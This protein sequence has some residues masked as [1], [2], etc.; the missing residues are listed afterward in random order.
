M[1]G[2]D[3]PSRGL[4]TTAK[5]LA[6]N[7]SR[8][9]FKPAGDDCTFFQKIALRR[10]YLEKAETRVEL[11]G[12]TLSLGDDYIP[13]SR[14]ANISAALVF[15][16]SG[17][18]V[19]LKNIDAYKGIDAKGKIAIVFSPPGRI[20]A[21]SNARR[22]HRQAWRRLYDRQRVCAETRRQWAGGH[23]DFHIWQTGI[24]IEVD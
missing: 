4:D 24:A 8:W 20:A 3:T 14:L 19:K 10:D 22:P 5:F 18:F 16:G 2:R 17:W 21:W 23:S 6:M 15:A 12:Q 1:E 11:N 13:Y 7:L 9:G